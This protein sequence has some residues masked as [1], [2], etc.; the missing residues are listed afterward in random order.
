MNV[1]SVPHTTMSAGA[2]GEWGL[3]PNRYPLCYTLYAKGCVHPKGSP[4]SHSSTHKKCLFLTQQCGVQANSDDKDL[5]SVKRSQTA[6]T[7]GVKQW[8][9]RFVFRVH[10]PSS[11][12]TPIIMKH[13]LYAGCC[14]EDGHG[15]HFHGT[16][17]P[18][19]R[20]TSNKET[21]ICQYG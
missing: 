8:S 20:Q 13:L 6:S 19:R 12:F 16:Y 7:L 2:R 18:W 10:G 21:N 1:Q 11:S 5:Q 9:K 17:R 14:A 4:F 15:L 3:G